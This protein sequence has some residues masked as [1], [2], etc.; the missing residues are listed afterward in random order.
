MFILLP[1]SEG[2]TDDP[3][4][5]QFRAAYPEYAH[6][7]EPLLR[8]M[9]ALKADALP[10]YY[11][12]RD[13]VSARSVHLA[14]LKCLDAGM[15][16]ALQRYT[17]VVY[18]HLEYKTLRQKAAARERILVVSALFGLV[19]GGDGLPWY[20]APMTPEAIRYWRPINASRLETLA[21]GRPVVSLLPQAHAKAVAYQPLI[22]ID[23]RTAGGAKSAGHFGKA[24]KGKFVRFLIEN[25]VTRP[26]DFKHF[27]EDGY[28][29]DGSNFV[30]A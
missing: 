10:S 25:K 16:P 30:K 6:D 21:K 28:R 18:Q 3:G 5:G 26:E 20:R 22:N 7:A 14:N 29:F 8:R 1:P 23:F 24:I 11:G 15:L 2:K 17:G 13:P 9:K 4:E 12:L 19:Q 27:N